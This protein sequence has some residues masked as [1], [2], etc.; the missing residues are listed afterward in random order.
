MNK[1]WALFRSYPY[2]SNVVGYTTLFATADLIQ[3]STLR[4]TSGPS[5][6]MSEEISRQ[7]ASVTTREEGATAHLKDSEWSMHSAGEKDSSVMVTNV[8]MHSVDWSQTLRVALVGL[9]FH[10]NFNYHWLRALEKRFPGGGA[11]IIFAKVFLDQLV[12]A[13]ATIS[14]FYIG[15]S[16]LEGRD[17]PLE[18]WKNKFWVSYKTGLVYWSIMQ[19]VNFTLVPPIARTVFVGG[20][21]LG[22]TVFLCHFRQQKNESHSIF[23]S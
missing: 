21:S 6:Q 13:P 2:I 19:A 7:A 5:N 16:T 4:G 11:K 12:A 20:I 8:P 17:D 3:Q 15:L 23:P 10:S 1:V 22:W 9:C 14:A 18:D